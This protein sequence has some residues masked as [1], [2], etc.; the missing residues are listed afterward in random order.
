M[1]LENN[2]IGPAAQG[3]PLEAC[4]GAGGGRLPVVSKGEPWKG[5][6]G[7]ARLQEIGDVRLSCQRLRQLETS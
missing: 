5:S 7:Y 3:V 2:R 6:A 4:R 1:N